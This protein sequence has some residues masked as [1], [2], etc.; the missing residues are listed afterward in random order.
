MVLAKLAPVFD[1]DGTLDR[2]S[3][4]PGSTSLFIQ[5]AHGRVDYRSVSA[6][7]GR[8]RTREAV[9][10]GSSAGRTRHLP[11][12]DLRERLQLPCDLM[13]QLRHTR[14]GREEMA[15][16]EISQILG[17]YGCRVGTNQ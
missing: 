7:L 4:R 10:L 1:F 3:D 15:A 9:V 11:S 14:A 12:H 5:R 16:P 13:V 8:I 2:L 6:H 17:R